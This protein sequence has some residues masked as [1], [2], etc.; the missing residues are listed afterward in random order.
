MGRRVTLY[1]KVQTRLQIQQFVVAVQWSNRL[2]AGF[3]Y[4]VGVF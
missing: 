3:G 2:G 4:G 1:K